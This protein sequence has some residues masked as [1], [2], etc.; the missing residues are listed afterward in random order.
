VEQGD[1]MPPFLLP[2]YLLIC[3][4]VDAWAAPSHLLPPL[5]HVREECVCGPS[6]GLDEDGEVLDH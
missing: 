4:P 6:I 3:Q 1:A 2:C 5:L